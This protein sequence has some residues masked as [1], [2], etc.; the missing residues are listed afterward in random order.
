MLLWPHWHN[1]IAASA[2]LDRFG[3]NAGKPR[4]L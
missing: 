4:N 2:K 3:V 1:G